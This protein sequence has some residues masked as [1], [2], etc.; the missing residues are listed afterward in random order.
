MSWQNGYAFLIGRT[1]TWQEA[2]DF[3]AS[4]ACLIACDP[5]VRLRTG[6]GLR[7]IDFLAWAGEDWYLNEVKTGYQPGRRKLVLQ[8]RKDDWL[9]AHAGGSNE[10]VIGGGAWWFL[11]SRITTLSGSSASFY[12]RLSND[13]INILLFVYRRGKGTNYN[14]VT[15]QNY[16]M[17]H[18]AESHQRTPRVYNY[19]PTAFTTVCPVGNFWVQ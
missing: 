11:P 4:F 1:F 16:A 12:Q 9:I 3:A 13:G 15:A 10:Y 6:L 8:A 5:Q 2:E 14:N 17:W 19:Y 18:A 7:V